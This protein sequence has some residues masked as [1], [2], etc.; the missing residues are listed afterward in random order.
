MSK[1]TTEVRFICEQKAGLEESVGYSQINNVLSNS[2]GKIFEPFPIWDEAYRPVLC[3]KI[4][5]HYY[6][7]EICCETVGL[8]LFWLNERMN[9]I[10]P[11]YNELYKT[12]QLEYNPLYDVDYTKSGNKEREE[13]EN[14]KSTLESKATNDLTENRTIKSDRNKSLKNEHEESAQSENETSVKSN[15]LDTYSDTPQGGLQ[16]LLSQEYL[17]NARN[18]DN[19]SKGTENQ[20]YSATGGYTNTETDTYS[21]ENGREEESTNDRTE[22]TSADKNLTSTEEYLEKVQG[23]MGGKSYTQLIQEYRDAI[24]NIDQMIIEEL[25]DLFFMLW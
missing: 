6:M 16:G 22:N 23:K 3:Q 24:I 4:L 5:K 8:W 18:I 1:Y 17:T 10:M 14:Q 13:A 21:E 11:Y 2:W 25:K 12:T 7:R 15:N 20:D 19:E 9:R